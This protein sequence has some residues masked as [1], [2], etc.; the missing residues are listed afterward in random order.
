LKNDRARVASADGD[1]RAANQAAMTSMV[2]L[3]L[4]RCSAPFSVTGSCERLGMAK[5]V[6]SGGTLDRCVS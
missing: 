1:S 5:A 6:G 4:S 2:G 3:P